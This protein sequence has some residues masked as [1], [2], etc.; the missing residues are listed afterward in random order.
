M[1]MKYGER[2]KA[3]RQYANL[4]QA[5]LAA[6]GPTSQANVSAL[7]GGEATGSDFTAQFAI[8]CGVNPLWLAKEEGTMEAGLYVT[9][10]DL[11]HALAIMEPFKEYQKQLAIKEIAE[12][13]E[14][15]A[16]VIERK[17]TL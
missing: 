13:V 14:H 9:D 7:E 4:T 2:L 6:S 8:A 11:K 10:P 15:V 16:E 1:L 17:R 5:Q 12:V 3:A